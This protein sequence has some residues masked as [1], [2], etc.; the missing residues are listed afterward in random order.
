MEFFTP[1]GSINNLD[2]FSSTDIIAIIKLRGLYVRYKWDK[3]VFKIGIF[4]PT[5]KSAEKNIC[6]EIINRYHLFQKINEGEV[7][8]SVIY[9]GGFYKR[10]YDAPNLPIIAIINLTRDGV[11]VSWDSLEKICIERDLPIISVAYQG[12]PIQEVLQKN[13]IVRPQDSFTIKSTKLIKRVRWHQVSF[14]N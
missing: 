7:L 11:F 14:I 12:K 1:E 4:S 3:N 6:T 8:Y 9:G 5:L 13:Y 10:D 2:K